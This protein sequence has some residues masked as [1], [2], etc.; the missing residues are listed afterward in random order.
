MSDGGS[1]SRGFVRRIRS[2]RDFWGGLALVAL[3]L[4]AL[5]AASDLTGMQGISLGD[6][7]APRLFAGL[8]AVAGAAIALMGVL[9]DGPPIEP[10]AVRRPAYVIAAIVAF[11]AMIRGVDLADFGVPLKT[12]G[13]GLAPS[14]FFA[15]MIAIMGSPEKRWLE[16]LLAAAAMTVFCVVLF[17]YLLNLPFDLWPEF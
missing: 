14:T 13:L 10:Y 3:A 12:P 9:I 11:A 2:P 4:F 17:V 8:L 7:T 6:G 5:W 16:S 1:F 15:F